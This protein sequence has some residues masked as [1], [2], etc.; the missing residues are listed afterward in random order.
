MSIQDLIMNTQDLDGEIEI[1]LL[2]MDEVSA[3]A[4]GGGIVSYT[5]MVSS[6]TTVSKNAFVEDFA[7]IFGKCRVGDN[8]IVKD[9]ATLFENVSVS[10]NACV[11]GKACLMGSVVVTDNARIFDEAMLGGSGTVAG[12]TVVKG[13]ARLSG[14]YL[15]TGE[16]FVEGD[17]NISGSFIFR[18]V[19][20]SA[21][22]SFPD[23]KKVSL[24][25][26]VITKTPGVYYN[27]E[28]VIICT[29]NCLFINDH[30]VNYDD[31]AWASIVEIEEDDE[32]ALLMRK[33]KTVI[34][35]MME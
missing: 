11:S 5:A 32:V 25:S 19:Y 15:L 9:E 17:I 6:E 20:I 4:K 31:V 28:V 8:A 27:D 24:K 35:S 30:R 7:R 23:W 12:Q 16:T 29:D 2:E 21:S 18:D 33:Y 14:K 1:D 22:A 13:K 10:K 26:A 3:H 34:E